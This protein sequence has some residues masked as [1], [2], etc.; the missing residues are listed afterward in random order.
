MHFFA[1]D[2]RYILR[3]HLNISLVSKQINWNDH[4]YKITPI[5]FIRFLFCFHKPEENVC[6]NLNFHKRVIKEFF[7]VYFIVST[8]KHFLCEFS[9][10]YYWIIR[11]QSIFKLTSPDFR[12]FK[13][14]NAEFPWIRKLVFFFNLFV[15]TLWFMENPSKIIW[16]EWVRRVGLFCVGF[17]TVCIRHLSPGW[18]RSGGIEVCCRHGEEAASGNRSKW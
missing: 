8:N 1:V 5:I 3:L 14:K 12:I 16:I 4:L 10:E 17:V 18:H 2:T 6:I 11:T 15:I 9:N 7:F 13:M